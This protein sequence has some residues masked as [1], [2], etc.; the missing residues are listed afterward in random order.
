VTP[1]SEFRLPLILRNGGESARLT[2][3]AAVPGGWTVL[4]A[5]EATL[6]QTGEAVDLQL[7]L[8][9][10][11][12]MAPSRELAIE[13]RAGDRVVAVLRLGVAVTGTLPFSTDGPAA[14][15]RM[16]RGSTAPPAS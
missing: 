5:P 10:P 13:V 9:A 16:P 14:A 2:I 12:T 4:A 11:A 7:R 15:Q 6:L 1:G 8:K 3:R